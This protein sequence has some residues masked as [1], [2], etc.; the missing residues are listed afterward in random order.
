M[1]INWLKL[2]WYN[3]HFYTIDLVHLF[4]VDLAS[5]EVNRM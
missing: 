5:K 1:N 3:L 2:I 4:S